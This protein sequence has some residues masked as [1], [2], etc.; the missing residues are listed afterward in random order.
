MGN[1]P[2]F[3]F[4]KPNIFKCSVNCNVKVLE[5]ALCGYG[6]FFIAAL[7]LNVSQQFLIKKLPRGYSHIVIAFNH[8]QLNFI[9]HFGSPELLLMIMAYHICAGN[10]NRIYFDCLELILVNFLALLL[11]RGRS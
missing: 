10:H 1:V 7:Q 11:F 5:K 9:H 3:E 6:K 4:D 2:D 8:L